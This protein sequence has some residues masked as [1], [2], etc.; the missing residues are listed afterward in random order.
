M[1]GHELTRKDQ[2]ISQLV[3]N[4]FLEI[5]IFVNSFGDLTCLGS[6]MRMSRRS[7]WIRG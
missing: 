3:C 6:I 1:Q 4:R 5:V 2:A 7:C